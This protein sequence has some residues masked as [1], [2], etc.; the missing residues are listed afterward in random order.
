MKVTEKM[1]TLARYQRTTKNPW[2]AKLWYY[3]RAGRMM[4]YKFKRQVPIGLYIVDFSCHEKRLIIELDGSG[5]AES[6]QRLKDITRDEF[7]RS[8]KY[9][10]LRFSNNDLS[11][12]LE[13][14]LEVVRQHLIS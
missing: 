2:E 1:I 7:L 14:I 6:Q 13:G 12:N 10:V 5:H 11:K 3:L 8:Q 4:G 9:T